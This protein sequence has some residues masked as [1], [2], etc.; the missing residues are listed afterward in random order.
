[1][2]KYAY[3]YFFSV[4]AL[5]GALALVI[6]IIVV[7]T[8]YFGNKK[9]NRINAQDKATHDQ[10]LG[11][12]QEY[13]LGMKEVIFIVS[14]IHGYRGEGA[15]VNVSPLAEYEREGLFFQIA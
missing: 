12:I 4:N 3:G 10:R 8:L 9:V 2:Q 6:S 13:F 7:I 1:M 5:V 15:L 11:I 14:P